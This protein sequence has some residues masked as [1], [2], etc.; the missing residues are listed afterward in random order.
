MVVHEV[1][2]A[3]GRKPGDPCQAVEFIQTISCHTV[4]DRVMPIKTRGNGRK[5]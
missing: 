2:A 1:L 4:W 3:A 5:I